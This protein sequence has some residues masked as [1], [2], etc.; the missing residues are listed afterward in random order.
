MIMPAFQCRRAYCPFVPQSKFKG[1]CCRSCEV[2]EPN[3]F[4]NHGEWCVGRAEGPAA[5]PGPHPRILREQIKDLEKEMAK[6]NLETLKIVAKSVVTF[7]VI[8]LVI[9]WLW[10]KISKK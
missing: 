9:K 6:P 8:K 5:D 3:E 4:T 10:N 7:E 2:A 1:F